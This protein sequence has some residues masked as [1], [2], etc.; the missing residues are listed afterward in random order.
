MLVGGTRGDQHR[1]SSATMC[2]PYRQVHRRCMRDVGRACM[3]LCTPVLA[4]LI[5]YPS[6]VDTDAVVCKT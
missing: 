1:G 4:H 5:I 6:A 2:Q 3:F